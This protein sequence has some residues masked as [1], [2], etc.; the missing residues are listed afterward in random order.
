MIAQAQTSTHAVWSIRE[1]G[2]KT[3][4]RH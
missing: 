1:V 2:P 4:M 3:E